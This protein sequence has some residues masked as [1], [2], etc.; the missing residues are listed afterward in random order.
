[1]DIN[2]IDVFLDILFP[3]ACE[4]SKIIAVTG[5]STQVRYGFSGLQTTEGA[6]LV[7][8]YQPRVGTEGQ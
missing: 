2:F 4:L 6:A 1:L 8:R 5:A 3:R 7:V